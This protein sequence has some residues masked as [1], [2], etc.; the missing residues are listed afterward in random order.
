[1]KHKSSLHGT[2]YFKVGLDSRDHK[3]STHLM[4]SEEANS[5][6]PI[7]MAVVTS[8][9]VIPC[10]CKGGSISALL[11]PSD[12]EGAWGIRG[13]ETGERLS[14]RHGEVDS[15][16]CDARSADTA[17]ELSLCTVAWASSVTSITLPLWGW[18]SDGVWDRDE[19]TWHTIEWY[20]ELEDWSFIIW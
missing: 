14:G 12:G 8:P 18:V 9:P 17:S 4:P 7:V 11:L 13:E 1:M 15:A 3:V 16:F 2:C 5:I 6:M 19:P 20:N 10:C